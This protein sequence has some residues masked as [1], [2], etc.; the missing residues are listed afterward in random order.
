[1]TTVF[2]NLMDTVN[3]YLNTTA[4][5]RNHFVEALKKREEMELVWQD[6]VNE[7][8]RKYVW[9]KDEEI[10]IF[11]P[12][13]SAISEDNLYVFIEDEDGAIWKIP[14]DWNAIMVKYV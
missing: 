5:A 4:Q 10:E 9:N 8:V 7:S 3:K 2:D 11:G 1:M 13:A 12:V 6:I 14:N